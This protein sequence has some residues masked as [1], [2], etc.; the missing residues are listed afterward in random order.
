MHERQ[1][2]RV[3]RLAVKAFE[4]GL[5]LG[6]GTGWQTAP[7][8]VDGIA[9]DGISDVRQVHT[10]LVRAPG[11]EAHARQRMRAKALLD[12]VMRDRRAAVAAHR[13]FRALRAMPADGLVD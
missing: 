6:C 11:L 8:A 12:A 13:H 1:A 10:D 2:R 5:E 4:R 9:D 7:A 3:Q